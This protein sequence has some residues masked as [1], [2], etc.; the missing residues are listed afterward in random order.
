VDAA[1][2]GCLDRLARASVLAVDLLAEGDPRVLARAADVVDST[3]AIE[4]CGDPDA[5]AQLQTSPELAVAIA[6]VDD[7]LARARALSAAGR[8]GDAL[9]ATRAAVVRAEAID[10]VGLRARALLELGWQADLAGA[11][12]EAM[13]AFERAYE[14]AAEARRDRIA[15]KAAIRLA[16]LLADRLGR[17]DDAALWLRQAEALV[18]RVGEDDLR[19]S[20]SFAV[21]ISHQARGEYDAALAEYQRSLDLRLAMH[22]EDH[23]D[24]HVVL[25]NMG[26]TF[27]ALGRYED[28]AEIHRRALAS[29]ER[30]YAPD[31]PEI[32]FSLNNLANAL[33][34]LERYDEA[35]TAYERSLEILR[36]SLGPDSPLLVRG[37]DN[38]GV[39]AY[40]E[41]RFSDA[42]ALLEEAMALRARTLGPDHPDQATSMMNLAS[43]AHT[44]GHFDDAGEWYRRALVLRERDA[45]PD[46]PEVA[47]LLHN[48]GETLADLG[49]FDEAAPIL[50]R[51]LA[52]REK[53]LPSIHPHTFGT[54]LVLTET[55]LGQGRADEAHTLVTD[56]LA[57]VP[58][59]VPLADRV[60]ADLLL[61]DAIIDRGDRDEALA[62]A[63]RLFDRIADDE[64][65]PARIRALARLGLARALELANGR[66]EATLALA[67]DALALAPPGSDA[68]KRISEWISRDPRGAT[69]TP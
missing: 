63:R 43:L 22:G 66:G 12:A 4:E 30:M 26:N 13:P 33:V 11:P 39:V 50:R 27:L 64:S 68:E 51:S 36:T 32:A 34:H 54:R 58:P 19:S 7:A 20:Y 6:E 24:V 29:R 48:L 59:S 23:S 8:Y 44:T 49:R 2:L 3:P 5:L 53:A 14:A 16:V 69:E 35:R 10:D 40:H 55:L 61:L 56:A 21:A 15:A 47:L 67:R 17:P 41:G 62:L 1:A 45:G 46:H 65:L 9:A 42:R 57:H 60:E 25:N 28:A 31:H 38:L 37:Y 52:I 18:E